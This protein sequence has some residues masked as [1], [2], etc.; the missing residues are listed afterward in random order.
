MPSGR[1]VPEKLHDVLALENSNVYVFPETVNRLTVGCT[2]K[3]RRSD[4]TMHVITNSRPIGSE[5]LVEMVRVE[6]DLIGL[7]LS[8]VIAGVGWPSWGASFA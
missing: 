5:V 2:P 7:V 8:C 1:R 6:S 4:A 3:V